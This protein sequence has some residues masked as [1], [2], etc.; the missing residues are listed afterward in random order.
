MGSFQWGEAVGLWLRP[1]KND[2]LHPLSSRRGQTHTILSGGSPNAARSNDRALVKIPS[3]FSRLN[4]STS[5][6]SVSCALNRESVRA[7]SF[8]LLANLLPQKA[9]ENELNELVG[10]FCVA[11]CLA[12]FV[13]PRPPDRRAPTTSRP[14]S[15]LLRLRPRPWPSIRRWW[16]L[17]EILSPSPCLSLGSS[18]LPTCRFPRRH[19]P[20]LKASRTASKRKA[21][22]M[23]FASRCG[24]NSRPVYAVFL[25]DHCA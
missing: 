11:Q 4:H 13:R 23:R 25:S 21:A 18:R 24:R 12:S 6:H 2:P 9:L 19:E 16:P 15:C 7:F 8:P 10:T 5:Q 1:G 3:A 20:R 14:L 22:T 17:Q